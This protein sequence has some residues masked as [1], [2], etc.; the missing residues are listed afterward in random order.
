MNYE[1]RIKELKAQIDALEAEMK[2]SPIEGGRWKPK[3]DEKYGFIDDT[4]DWYREKWLNHNTDNHRYS[5]GNCYPA[6]EDGKEQAIWE[7]VTRRKY[8]QALRDAADLMDGSWWQ[9]QWDTRENMVEA[10]DWC[11]YI[12]AQPRFTTYESCLEAHCR[13]LGK[14]AKRYF[15]GEK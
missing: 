5:M 14:D 7:Q 1:Q 9:A 13:I 6:T 11:N 8:D 2:T 12:T 15:T 4:G 3:Y 10:N